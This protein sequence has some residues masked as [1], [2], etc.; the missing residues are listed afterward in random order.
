MKNATIMFTFFTLVLWSSNVF[1]KAEYVRQYQC[2]M[3]GCTITCITRSEGILEI[4]EAREI[5]MTIYPS[6]TT[7]F[8]A[9]I[10]ISERKS[11][12][13]GENGVCRIEHE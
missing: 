4:R 13:T 8:E 12:V 5:K 11:I 6:G 2:P 10:G 7:V 1:G 9:Q 3:G